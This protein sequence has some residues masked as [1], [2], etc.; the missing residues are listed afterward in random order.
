MT[1]EL[2]K[3]ILERSRLTNN[4]LIDKAYKNRFLY[5]QQK[6]EY[7]ALVRITKK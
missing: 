3:K 6:N 4:F 7:F 5:T 2:S 1:K